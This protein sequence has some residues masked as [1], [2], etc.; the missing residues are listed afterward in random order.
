MFGPINCV[1]Y[2]TCNF[3][4]KQNVLT[5]N[6]DV[7]TDLCNEV[8][9]EVEI[10]STNLGFL[11]DIYFQAQFAPNETYVANTIQMAYSSVSDGGSYINI[12]NPTPISGGFEMDVS[13]LNTYLNTVGLVG[14]KDLDSKKLVLGSVQLLLVICFWIKGKISYQ[15]I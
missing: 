9:Y 5:P 6:V 8:T 1:F 15:R 13:T 14:S 11:R 2:L 12:P 10:L 7:I 4:N 3:W